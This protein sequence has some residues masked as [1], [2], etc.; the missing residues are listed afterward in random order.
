MRLLLLLGLA[1]AAG[2]LP[3]SAAVAHEYRA[4]DLVIGHPWGRAIGAAAPTAAGY[5]SL[6]N[7]GSAP[8]RLL[9]ARSPAARQVEIHAMTMTDGVMRMRPLAEGLAIPPRGTAWLR[10]GGQH[11]MLVGPAGPFVQGSRIP[12]T[13]RFERAGEITVELEVAAAGARDQPAQGGH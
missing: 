13:L 1:A 7:Q 3:L 9:D 12:V 10:P 2:L 4:G 5:M 8:D 11:L 6:S